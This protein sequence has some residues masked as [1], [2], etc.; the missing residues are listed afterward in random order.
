MLNSSGRN[1]VRIALAVG[2]CIFGGL[3][4]LA[5]AQSTSAM[6][7][8]AQVGDKL[9]HDVNLSASRQM[10]CASCHDPNNHYAQSVGNTRSVQL[11]GPNLT[12]PGFRAVPTLTYKDLMPVYQ[13]QAPNPD[14]VT[15]DAPGGGFTWD[16]RAN[17]LAEQ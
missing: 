7:L 11:G 1:A 10:A 16:G 9:F 8:Q 12:T 14:N 2:V 3:A 13:D 6:S 15:T 17:T 4:A 5:W